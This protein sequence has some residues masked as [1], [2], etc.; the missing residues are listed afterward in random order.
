MSKN[1]NWQTEEDVVWDDLPETEPQKP[2]DAKRRW[3]LLITVAIL[4]VAAGG[5]IFYRVDQRADENLE[6]MRADLLSS[7]NLVHFADA[8]QDEELFGSLLSGRDMAWTE[9][10]RALLTA[11]LVVNREPFGLAAVSLPPATAAGEEE[12]LDIQLSP[13]LTEAVLTTNQPFTVQVGA[14]V[15][16]TVTLQQTAVYRL[17]NQRWLLAPPQTEFWGETAE[18]NGATLHLSYPER[19]AE[20]ATK[21]H[22]DLE[23]KLQEMCRLAVTPD[24]SGAF[25]VDVSF[26]PDPRT[27]VASERPAPVTQTDGRLALALPTPTLVG[28]PTDQAGYEALYRG[29]ATQLVTAVIS[30][31][32]K[33]PCCDHAPFFQALLDYQLSLL[34][35]RPWPVTADDYRRVLDERVSLADLVLLWNQRGA[36]ALRQP[37]NWPAYALVDFLLQTYPAVTPTEMQLAFVTRPDLSYWLASLYQE[38]TAGAGNVLDEMSRRWWLYAFGQAYEAPQAQGSDLPAQRVA[39][40][41]LQGTGGDVESTTRYRYDVVANSWLAQET[42]NGFS[43]LSPLANNDATLLET[44]DFERDIWLAHLL[45]DDEKILLAPT[46]EPFVLSFG[47]VDP[48]GTLLTV[49][50]FSRN[51]E[52]LNMVLL[53]LDQ[54]DGS[55]CPTYRIPGVPTWS[56]DGTQALVSGDLS[57]Q[58]TLLQLDKRTVSFDSG[59]PLIGIPLFRAGRDALLQPAVPDTADLRR[60][61]SGYAPFWLD[62]E[63][64]GYVMAQPGLETAVMV[65]STRDDQSETLLEAAALQAALPQGDSAANLVIRYVLVA[66]DDPQTLYVVA[67]DPSVSQ[68]H[69]FAYD[70]AGGSVQWL[71]Q[72]G[73]TAA[74][75]LGLSP[76][77]RYLILSGLEARLQTSRRA[78][79]QSAQLLLHDRD[80]GRTIPFETVTPFFGPMVLYDWTADSRWLSFM[81]N[82]STLALLQPETN[83]LQ[84]VQLTD[85]GCTSPLWLQ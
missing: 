62:N 19:D 23:R 28:L 29:Y 63:T 1:F 84:L 34:S 56:P 45:R 21:L 26:S 68:A 61:G 78:S 30:H 48:A 53:Q 80:T 72:H 36:E 43:F 54:C 58:L 25:I 5:Y 59:R 85:D 6:T 4:L 77:G 65:A 83:Y 51:S 14:R 50:T 81:S 37:E 3:P 70:R 10:Q 64:Y 82:G 57:T 79:P 2:N 75:S 67:F 15:S 17:G 18:R 20:I 27:L 16:E 11:D 40:V 49:Y 8:E 38:E 7:Y 22:G 60:I 32:V 71:M 47:Q 69:V 35:L 31:L 12:P 66:P 9:A 39:L 44:Y 73:N 41:C 76:D 33:Y 46:G 52:V 74:H 42:T 24:C 13:D 55:D